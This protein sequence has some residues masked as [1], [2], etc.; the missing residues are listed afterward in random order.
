M[1]SSLRS[2]CRV[3]RIPQRNMQRN[4]T[5]SPLHRRHRSLS[6]ALLSAAQIT[7][8]NSS[9]Q[10]IKSFQTDTT[11]LRSRR[12]TPSEH[13]QTDF[14]E[15]NML[16]AMPTPSTSVD[17]CMYDGFGLNSGITITGG[18]GALLVNGEAFSWTPWVAKGS[19]ELANKRGQFELPREAFGLFDLLWPRP[20]TFSAL[21]YL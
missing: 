1:A 13:P 20:G 21:S 3:W 2:C 14:N 5:S 12:A 9:I 7:S 15:L 10:H 4:M 17:V 6:T 18:K 11:P 8:I 19:L 16:G